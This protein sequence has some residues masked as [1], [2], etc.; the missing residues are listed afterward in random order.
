MSRPPLGRGPTPRGGARW[1]GSSPRTDLTH[2]RDV[3]PDGRALAVVAPD[4]EIT[5]W[6]VLS[7]APARPPVASAPLLTGERR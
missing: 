7:C 4:D 2:T 1:R 5:A 6:E 3:A